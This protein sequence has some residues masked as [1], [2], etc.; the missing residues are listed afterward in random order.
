MYQYADGQAVRRG[1]TF[2][3]GSLGTCEVLGFTRDNGARIRNTQ[4]RKHQTLWAEDCP[5]WFG[6]SDLWNRAMLEALASGEMKGGRENA[7]S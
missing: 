3:Q 5:I 1:D 2:C 4:T 6:E 7:N